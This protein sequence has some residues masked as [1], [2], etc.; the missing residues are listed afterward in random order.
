MKNIGAIRLLLSANFISGIAQGISMISIPAYFASS[1]QSN[2]FNIAYAIITCVSLFWS[3]YGGTLIDKYNRKHIFLVLNIVNA[4]AIGGI[5][6]LEGMH[7]GNTNYWA[8]A[9]FALTFWNYNL[10]YPCFYAFM[11]EITERE[12]YNK[13]ASYIEIQ[14][15]MASAFAGAGA[16]LLLGGGLTTSFFVFEI[17]PWTLSQIFALDACTYFVALL[18]IYAIRFVPIVERKEEQGTVRERL[19]VGYKFLKTRP[20][21]FLFGILTHAVFVVTLLH[22]FNLAPLYVAQHLEAGAQVFAI[23]EIFYATGAIIA[24]VAIHKI[25]GGIAFVKAIIIM[26]LITTLE[27]IGLI[28]SNEV[29]VFYLVSVCLGIT[30]AG[31]RV[32]RISYLFKVL[33][34]QV[35]GRVN[36]IFFLSNIMAR[37]I[38][39]TLFSLTF[40]H[41]SGNVIYAFLTLSIFIFVCL[42]ILMFFYTKHYFVENPKAQRS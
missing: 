17:E 25:F 22:I 18:I 23:S 1:E 13:I 36:S 12:N 40:F 39:L 14:S 20:Y 11:Q 35:M 32:I 10:H 21:I 4:I 8:A 29:W 2:W 37:I 6:Y 41:H 30:N 33:P 15:Q 19:K 9:V 26:M 28:A 24:G 16:A 38:F 27:L 3:I 5:A 7:W 34:N 31:I 42:L